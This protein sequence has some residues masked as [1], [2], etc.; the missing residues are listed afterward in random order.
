[1]P[2]TS[3]PPQDSP[4]HAAKVQAEA[5]L[6]LADKLRG[7]RRLPEALVCIDKAAAIHDGPPV[8]Y[9]RAR[10]LQELGRHTDALA[11]IDRA[12]EMNRQDPN[13]LSYRGWILLGMGRHDEA[14]A[15][16]DRALALQPYH[17]P[18]LTVRGVLLQELGL[19]R[20]AKETFEMALAIDPR[21]AQVRWNRALLLLK[22]GEFEAGWREYEWRWENA[23]L[24]IT[25]PSLGPFWNGKPPRAGETLLLHCEQGLGDTL[26]F[27]RLAV[28]VARTTPARVVLV[29]PKP[30]KALL[31]K[32]EGIAAVYFWGERLPP[33]DHWCPLL[34]LPHVLG[35]GESPV[36][37]GP[38]VHAPA[39]KVAEWQG[40]LPATQAPRIAL[41]WS[42]SPGHQ[43]DSRRSLALKELLSVLPQG[44]QYLSL[45][46][47]H[48]DGDKE[49]LAA[50]PDILE[51]GSTLD[52]FTDTAALCQ[53]A[54][55]VITVDTSVAHLAGA[56]GRPL[57][58]MSPFAPDWRWQLERSDSPWY[59]TARLFR[60]D[61]PLHWDGM[62]HQLGMELQAWLAGRQ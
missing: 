4:E 45:Q 51:L 28:E 24:A 20:A 2:D 42:G 5:M 26:Q 14:M 23:S 47:K 57:W 43:R 1:M 61:R 37:R 10:T 39:E 54:D 56:L 40:K 55:L 60:Q 31:E 9:A 35:L 36:W 59:P 46:Q 53:L 12:L 11:D 7:Q 22:L 13:L 15:S 44:P 29:V 33:F 17:V 34:S 6:A 27:C 38:Y 21:N 19:P 41:V 52:D 18:T 48:R 58:V 8:R 62:L 30:L 32:M 16:M 50:R 3:A 49:L 25:K